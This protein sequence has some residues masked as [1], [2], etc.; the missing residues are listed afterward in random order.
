MSTQRCRLPDRRPHFVAPVTHAGIQYTVG[1]GFFPDGSPAEVFVTSAKLGTAADVAARDSAVLLSLLLQ[2]S[3]PLETIQGALLRNPNGSPA[4]P[5]GAVV[6]LLSTE[7][8]R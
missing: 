2:H 8:H 4:G 1:C 7:R 6:D 3:C 5:I